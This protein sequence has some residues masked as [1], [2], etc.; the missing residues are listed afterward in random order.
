MDTTSPPLDVKQLQRWL[1][2]L[3]AILA[4][5][6]AWTGLEP[7]QIAQTLIDGLVKLLDLEFA[8]IRLGDSAEGS[9]SECVRSSL[10]R[11]I[12][13]HDVAQALAGC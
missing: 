9:I 6:A 3:V 5:P 8:Y 12:Q 2:G 1:N 4:L 7:R 13:P 10:R 11:D